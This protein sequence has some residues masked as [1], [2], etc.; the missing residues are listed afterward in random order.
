M[1]KLAKR[2]CFEV[3]QKT[4]NTIRV[5]WSEE[6]KTGLGFEIGPSYD[7]VPITSQCATI[8]QSS[9]TELSGVNIGVH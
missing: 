3:L 8:L 4:S 2:A 6:S 7:D 1:L 5:I 9:C